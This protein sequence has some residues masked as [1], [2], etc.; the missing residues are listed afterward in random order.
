MCARRDSHVK[1]QQEGSHLQADDRGLRTVQPC[2]HLG[3]EFPELEV[4]FLF[5]MPPSL[6]FLLWPTNTDM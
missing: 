5:S 2:W 3:L 4:K 1:G 6:S